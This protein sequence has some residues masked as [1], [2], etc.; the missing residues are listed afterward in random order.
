MI[1]RIGVL[2]IFFFLPLTDG[3][4]VQNGKIAVEIAKEVKKSGA[5][6]IAFIE[7]NMKEENE[8]AHIK[9]AIKKRGIEIVPLDISD[10]IR[11]NIDF[12]EEINV[13]AMKQIESIFGINAVVIAEYLESDLH[14][15]IISSKNGKTIFKKTI[16]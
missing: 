12:T 6:R 4:C 1:G 7:L 15:K 14:M 16:P 9:S 8:S 5:S 2:L 11:A 3:Y 10:D 13:E